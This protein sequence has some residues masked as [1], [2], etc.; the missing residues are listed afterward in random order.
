MYQPYVAPPTADRPN[1]VTNATINTMRKQQFDNNCGKS[2]KTLHD[3]AR[4]PLKLHGGRICLS[5]HSNGTCF[6]N[7]CGKCTGQ[8]LDGHM[9]LVGDKV[10]NRFA[11]FAAAA[12]TQA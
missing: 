3:D 5:W 6:S 2:I 10:V 12:V 11:T 9:P 8:I 1:I 7:C 4:A